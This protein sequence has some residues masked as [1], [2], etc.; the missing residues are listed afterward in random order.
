[1]L[2]IKEVKYD[3]FKELVEFLKF[4]DS[5]EEY[6]NITKRLTRFIENM[7]AVQSMFIDNI[8]NNILTDSPE[9]EKSFEVFK[10]TYPDLNVDPS[11]KLDLNQFQYFEITLESVNLIYA[12][13]QEHIK[14]GKGRDV[15]NQVINAK[16]LEPLIKMEGKFEYPLRKALYFKKSNR[17]ITPDKMKNAEE[18]I[19]ELVGGD[20]N[21]MGK[22]LA[23]IY[24]KKP[25]RVQLF[26]DHFIY[27]LDILAKDKKLSHPDNQQFLEN[28]KKIG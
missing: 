19:K 25:E 7:N 28:L 24:D 6:H 26:I 3:E 1:M 9:A 15:D 10:E 12:D 20:N 14:N 13:A 22:F 17:P 23:Y 27:R 11:G 4:D 18:E 16:T 5:T 21:I 8:V 2:K